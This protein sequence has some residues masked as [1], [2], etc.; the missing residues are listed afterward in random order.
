MYGA[1]ETEGFLEEEAFKKDFYDL[2]DMVRILYEEMNTR[3]VGESSK[4]PHGEGSLEDKK[5][6]GWI[7]RVMEESLLHLHH[8]HLPHHIHHPQHLKQHHLPLPPQKLF[9]LIQKPQRKKLPYSNW[10]LILNFPCKME[11]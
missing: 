8:I 1:R 2:T 7:Q 11:R 9:I 3:M 5:M 10:K 4:S 6:K